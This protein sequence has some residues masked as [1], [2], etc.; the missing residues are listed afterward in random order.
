MSCAV[1]VAT[2]RYYCTNHKR[3]SSVMWFVFAWLCLQTVLH[4]LTFSCLP[5]VTFSLTSCHTSR[6]L[7]RLNYTH[8]WGPLTMNTIRW[9]L[10]SAEGSGGS[11]WSRKRRVPHGLKTPPA[12][13][14]VFYS[15]SLQDTPACQ[16]VPP[17]KLRGME[18]PGSA[19]WYWTAIRAW[20]LLYI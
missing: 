15:S 1:F 7:M 9:S 18:Q 13:Q 10:N 3:H 8:S 16:A 19:E 4:M 2:W 6:L 17:T 20:F 14:P 5:S 12:L 11:S